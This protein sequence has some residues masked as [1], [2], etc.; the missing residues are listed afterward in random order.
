[1]PRAIIDLEPL[2]TGG[3]AELFLGRLAAGGRLVVVKYLQDPSDPVAVRYF[4]R[5]VRILGKG[6]PRTGRVLWANLRAKR[7]YYV[8]P[9]YSGGT[10]HD[11][12][13]TLGLHRLHT[14]LWRLAL[15]VRDLH[16]AGIVHG[17]IK[18]E[19]V[20]LG[21]AGALYLIDPLGS[22]RGCTRTCGDDSGGTP[23]YW[24]PEVER[25]GA[26]SPASDVF[27][28]GV[29]LAHL[30]TGRTPTDERPISL[31]AVA[32]C[33]PEELTAVFELCC[34]PEPRARP[35]MATVAR[36]LRPMVT[37]AAR[38]PGAERVR[39]RATA[40]VARAG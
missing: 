12:A 37:R 19:N 8:M 32:R 3:V 40:R 1:M 38:R 27:S 13:G 9:Y 24:A 17:D 15:T 18:P 34:Q 25:G 16:Q 4:R 31:R 21:R 30:A 33:L 20:L 2:I 36:W 11:L 5:E 23:G 10:L 26:I 6:I 7:P 29:S 22:G 14:V 39:P 35:G 28:F